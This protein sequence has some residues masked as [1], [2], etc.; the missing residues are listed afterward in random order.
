MAV[1][2]DMTF[3]MGYG[4]LNKFVKM[5]DALK[6]SDYTEAS[7]QVLDSKYAR[8]VTKNRALRNAYALRNQ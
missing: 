2:I 6:N 3:N 5:W 4:G 7:R 8:S 1:L